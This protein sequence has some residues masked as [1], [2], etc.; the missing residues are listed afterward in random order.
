MELNTIPFKMSDDDVLNTYHDIANI[1][2]MNTPSNDKFPNRAYYKRVIYYQ[3]PL[4]TIV[5]VNSQVPFSI[6]DRILCAFCGYQQKMIKIES[7]ENAEKEFASLQ[8][9]H[10]MHKHTIRSATGNNIIEWDDVTHW[11]Y[12][13]K[14]K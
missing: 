6:I 8:D 10:I 1:V 12:L 9:H 5:S 13:N 4:V 2:H 14:F 11:F 3:D 7:K